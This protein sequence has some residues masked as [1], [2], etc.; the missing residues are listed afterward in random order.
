MTLAISSI[1]ADGIAARKMTPILY[2]PILGIFMILN[3]CDC[4][5]LARP[6]NESFNDD[7]SI[8]TPNIPDDPIM[9]ITCCVESVNGTD[10]AFLKPFPH[11]ETFY[12]YPHVNPE[13]V[14]YPDFVN[15]TWPE[16]HVDDTNRSEVD[17]QLYPFDD[18]FPLGPI[19][20][21]G[22]PPI[23]R[24]T[25]WNFNNESLEPELITWAADDGHPEPIHDFLPVFKGESKND[26]KFTAKPIMSI[27][28]VLVA[29]P[30]R[31]GVLESND[32][33]KN[34]MKITLASGP[35]LAVAASA[36]AEPVAKNVVAK[37]NSSTAAP[38]ATT[39]KSKKKRRKTTA[40]PT[41]TTTTKRTAGAKR[42]NMR[43]KTTTAPTAST[44]PK[45]NATTGT[46]KK[47]KRKVTTKAGK[48]IAA[49]TTTRTTT[50][51]RSN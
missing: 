31:R 21:L 36:G 46:R 50:T 12:P 28:P 37:A 48:A 6:V 10:D 38:G 42:A 32:D 41:T 19:L 35:R 47:M 25:T 49:A 45:T 51:K 1:P 43:K 27:R 44:T 29:H 22:L 11:N 15:F 23:N 2:I 34:E 4:L 20:G 3:N 16:Y 17:R 8:I 14:P 18:Y 13:M 5:S 33:L 26:T 9:S 24:P 30:N 7:W 39:K 40:A